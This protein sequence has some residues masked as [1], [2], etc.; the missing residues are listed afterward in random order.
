MKELRPVICKTIPLKLEE[1]VLYISKEHGTAIH[2][3]P[4][5]CGQQSIIS[6]QP[7]FK[8]GWTLTENGD[9]VTIRPSILNNPCKAHYYITENQI[10]ML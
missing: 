6:L 10:Q 8:S 5:G 9:K 1:G 3:C 7:T 2:L 4:C